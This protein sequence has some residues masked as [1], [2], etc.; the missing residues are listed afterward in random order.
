MASGFALEIERNWDG[1]DATFKLSR[2]KEK[3]GN[4]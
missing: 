2:G 3:E 1:S 4:S